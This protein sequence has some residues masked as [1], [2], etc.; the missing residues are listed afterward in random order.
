MIDKEIKTDK[1][2][3]G[4][5]ACSNIC[6]VNSISMKKNSEGFWYPYVN[7][8]TCI[9]CGKCVDVCPIINFKQIDNKPHAYACIN[10]N[11]HE[12]MKSSSGSIFSII[13]NWILTE[14]GIVYGA[15]FDDNFNVIHK[16]A[17][18]VEEL[19]ELRGSKYVQSWIGSSYKEIKSYLN[20]GRKILF[21]GTPCQVEGL[22]HYLNK[23][24]E[25]LYTMD[26]VCHGVPSPKVWDKYLR[27]LTKKRDEKPKYIFFRDK[28]T[29]WENFSLVFKY[30]EGPP[31]KNSHKNDLYMQAFL[32]NVCLRPSCYACHF[33]GINRRSDITMAVFWGINDVY[34]EINDN[35]GTSLIL[36]NTE[37]GKYMIEANE[38]Y[39]TKKE[40]G[41]DLA[42]KQNSAAIKSAEKNQNRENFFKELNSL[43]FNKLVSKYCLKMHWIKRVYVD[44][45][46]KI[47]KLMT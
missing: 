27:Y 2:C 16:K 42:L 6:P 14:N 15:A 26:I 46:R 20:K 28:I 31:I 12:R 33:K 32:K 22:L 43:S 23:N 38:R 19:D 4:C 3:M 1:D 7:Y 47:K 11:E 29:G 5:Q 39:M 44:F 9:G 21:T 18:S 24:Y 45:R 8:E 35:K 41:I 36:V 30:N 13:A 10:N 37:K 17:E 34:P 25:N 40:V